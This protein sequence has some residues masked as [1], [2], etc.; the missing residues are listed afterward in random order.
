MFEK[1]KAEAE[2]YGDCD[3]GVGPCGV[4]FVLLLTLRS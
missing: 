1:R 2:A 3:F 4:S